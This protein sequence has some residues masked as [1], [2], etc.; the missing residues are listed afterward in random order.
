MEVI[1]PALVKR[2]KVDILVPPV[3]EAIVVVAQDCVQQRTVRAC[4]GASDSGERPS[5]W[6]WPRRTEG[7][8]TSCR[9]QSLGCWLEETIEVGQ[10]KGSA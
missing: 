8:T 4:A 7:A 6:Y 2:I 3:M 10:V 9:A 1:Q 5:R